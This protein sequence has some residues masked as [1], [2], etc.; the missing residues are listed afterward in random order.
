MATRANQ[1]G[2]FADIVSRFGAAVTAKLRTGAGH[3]EAQL[4]DPF[5]CV[6][7]EAGAEIGVDVLTIDETPLDV[8][9]VRPDFMIHT[10][11]AQAGFA[12]LK[13]RGRK[14]PTTWT[15][16]KREQ[17]Q[18]EKLRLLP[19]VLYSD[20][21]QWAVYHFGE[22]F[23]TVA[24]LD[25]DLRTAG[26]AL[27]PVDEEFERVITEFLLWNPKPP[28]NIDDLVKAVANLCGL[29]RDE[30]STT[31]RREQRGEE[32]E[33]VFSSLAADWRQYLFPDLPDADFADDY[34]Q[35]VTFAL[36]LA[37]ADGIS[38]EAHE[39]RGIARQLGEKHSLM[40][41]ALDVLTER[42]VERRSVAIRTMLRVIGAVDWDDLAKR[43]P[44]IYFRLYEHF[45]KKYDPAQRRRSGSYYTP[46]QVVTFMVR[47]TEEVLRTRMRI[48]WGMASEDVR[49]VDPAM[50]TGSYLLSVIDN[51]ARTI[52]SEE[53]KEA[54]GPQLRALFGRLIGFERQAC[55]YAV[56]ELGI[57]QALRT[58]HAK[59]PQNEVQM[60]LADTLDDP[61]LEQTHIPA[62]LEPIARSRRE[63]NRIKLQTPIV[64]VI[65]NPPYGAKAGGKGGW[66]ESGD[67]GH[68][69]P[70]DAFRAARR[71]KYEHVLSNLYVYFWRWATWKV[72][73]AHD[74]HPA[75]IVTLITPSS[76]TTGVGYAGMR[77]YLRRTGDEGWII[78][79]FPEKFR[80][81]AGKRVFRE[82]PHELSVA[83]F[84][85]YGLPDPR[86]PA[87]I[88]Y[89]AVAGRQ[90]DKF[91]ALTSLGIDDAGW[92][93]C[94]TGWQDLLRPSA[95][96]D[97][98]QFPALGDLM[99]WA[100]SSVKPNRG[101]VYAPDVA[102]LQRRWER[103]IQADPDEKPV[104][105]KQTRDRTIASI[106]PPLPG[107]PGA[108]K[109]LGKETSTN[110]RIERVAF[111]S[112]DRQHL[113][114][115]G[116]VIDFAKP[117][118]WQVRGDRQVYVTEQHAHPI[119]AGLG[120]T[121]AAYVPDI[122]HF[123][124]RGG[125]VLPLYRDSAGLS[126]NIAPG[127]IHALATHLEASVTAEDVL[128]YVA[129]IVAHP[130][131]T[132]RFTEELKTPGIRVPLTGD[133]QL[134]AEAVGLGRR[135]LWLHTYGERFAD[136][137]D[138]RPSGPPRLPADSQ[139][140]VTATIP[141]TDDDMPREISYDSDTRTLQVGEGA[142]RPVSQRV[143][144]YE[145]SRMRIIRKW[146]DYRKKNPRVRW[147]SPLDDTHAPRWTARFTSDLL[148]LINVLGLCIDLEPHQAE[149]LDRVCAGPLFTVAD[150]EHAH[151]FPVPDVAGKPPAVEHPDAPT[152]F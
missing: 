106:P 134:W 7:K 9:G 20:G 33:P 102:T 4:R 88:H 36:L 37:R 79:L 145:V 25:G 46:K 126:P 120:L 42:S 82:V 97:W 23:G 69:P 27:R 87:R 58:H 48:G 107:V 26:S 1:T 65:G 94:A 149:L 76:F 129:G 61:N 135:V 67:P 15:P 147:S 142:I 60:F 28:R 35:T 140:R 122:D 52:T 14:V 81:D 130:A 92:S 66:I 125:R 112:F 45:L 18:W 86:T 64:V 84:V 34:A 22:L 11:G 55:P 40:G 70:L 5:A 24:Q 115:D 100:R 38:F 151:V 10:A 41:K 43:N 127:L 91:R 6:L 119:D 68:P 137:S 72:F 143:W 110:A 114:Y 105:L 90:E 63:A 73:D 98:Q 117:S 54:V 57:Y 139:P 123:N 101:W 99:P 77:E 121:F 8:L 56:A 47:F 111:R 2:A 13:A 30:V 32:R 152:L 150:L 29:L 95:G 116:R 21:E 74:D 132:A 108:T 118:L 109:A 85:R 71:G 39:L 136:P 80:S 96:L 59:V 113:I 104:L 19:N 128:A 49:I 75:G 83:V 124:A 146:F 3:G 44:D 138:G 78:D 144:D 17:Q 133:P 31:L 12:E 50:G 103:L 131:Y 148:E 16:T 141:D 93:D 53:G 51:V 62:T 89:L